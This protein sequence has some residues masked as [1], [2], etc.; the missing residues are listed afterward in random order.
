MKASHLIMLFPLLFVFPLLFTYAREAVA[1][2]DCQAVGGSFDFV[3]MRCDPTAVHPQ[4]PFALRHGELI[5]L[6]EAGA[7]SYLG[8]GVWASFAQRRL[9]RRR[10]EAAGLDGP[11][12][13]A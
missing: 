13:A 7:F 1:V 5:L 6:S 12:G 10:L 8:I 3:A 9:R 11:A 2:D 4:I